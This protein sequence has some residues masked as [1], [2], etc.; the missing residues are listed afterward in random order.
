MGESERALTMTEPTPVDCHFVEGV[1]IEVRDEFL[2]IV[3]FIDL[4]TSENGEPERRIV[5]RAAL[6]TLVARALLRDLRK[7]VSRGGN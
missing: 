7:A 2:R 1:K 5:V 3:G 4:E 6:P